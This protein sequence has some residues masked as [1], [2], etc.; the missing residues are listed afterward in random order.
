MDPSELPDTSEKSAFKT[1][2]FFLLQNAHPNKE[3]PAPDVERVRRP[4]EL[5][6]LGRVSHANL[7][8]P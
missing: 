6:R 4:S 8:P 2:F 7:P 5:T 3:A 1:L